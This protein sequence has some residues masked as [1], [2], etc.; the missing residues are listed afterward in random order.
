MKKVAFY[1]LGCK[2]NQY[3]TEAMTELFEKEGYEIT[4]FDQYADVYVI[5]TCTVTNLGDRKSRQMIR[6]AKKLNK[7]SIVAVVGCYAQTAA[8]EISKIK[9]V[10][11]IIGTK[12]RSRIVELINQIKEQEEQINVVQDIMT[13]REFE[14]MKVTA[15]KERTRAFLKIQEGCNQFCSYCIIPYARGPVRSRKPEDIVEE[16]QQLAQNGFKEIVFAGIHV[17]SYGKDLKNTNLLDIIKRVHDIE[18]IERLRLSSIEPMILTE[19]FVEN[20]ARLPK[21]C[22]HYHISLQSGCDAT[23]KRMNRKYTTAEYRE[24]VNR[25]R[26]NFPDVAI[27]TDV[28]VGF[29]GETEQ[30]F[31]ESKRFVDEISFA[32][33]HVFKYSPRKGTP[34]VTFPNQVS[35]EEK[36]RRS[37]IMIELSANSEKRF[38]DKFIG[39]EMEVLFEQQVKEQDGY[40]EGLTPNY[41]R[42]VAH[43]DEDIEGQIMKVQLKERKEGFIAGTIVKNN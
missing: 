7:H 9:G 24:V 18:G 22:P 5:N 11:L 3:E 20:A 34:S 35:P 42:V 21:L 38:C 29:P 30:E 15:Y 31:E 36:E 12:D 8:E 4:D 43:S 2:V 17:A 27:T 32:Q 10:N 26:A 19:E 1:T 41:I 40:Y 13:T 6:R 14:D 39:R 33:V 25:L 23:L 37:K 16:V 28:M